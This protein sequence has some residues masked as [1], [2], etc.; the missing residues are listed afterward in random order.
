MDI[1]TSMNLLNNIQGNQNNPLGNVPP[2]NPNQ[3]NNQ[4]LGGQ[5]VPQDIL[6]LSGTTPVSQIDARS[7]NAALDQMNRQTEAFQ[8]MIQRLLNLQ[9][10]TATIVNGQ[11]MIQVDEAT[12]AQAQR[13]IADDGYFGVEQTSERILGF[14]RAFAGDDPRRIE[15]MRDAFLAGF[16]AAERAWGGDLPEISQRTF[17]A[18]MAGFD[19]MLGINQPA[20]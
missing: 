16:A 1:N 18:V 17:D 4:L 19:Q 13:D 6:S 11:S 14:A 7:I 2:V 10:H 12:M 20:E 8:Q 5:T 9:G 3:A 15:L